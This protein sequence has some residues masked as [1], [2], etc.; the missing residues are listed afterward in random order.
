MNGIAGL[1]RKDLSGPK[2]TGQQGVDA[3]GGAYIQDHNGWHHLGCF[4]DECE[5]ALAYNCAAMESFG[6][7]ALL[8]EVTK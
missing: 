6:E 2:L 5:A 3:C 8:N 1:D 4:D 7:F